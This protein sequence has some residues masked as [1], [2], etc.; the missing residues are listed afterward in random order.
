MSKLGK[1]GIKWSF[2][3]LIKFEKDKLVHSVVFPNFKE[4]KKKRE[5]TKNQMQWAEFLYF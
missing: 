2:L 5:R 1:E 3:S 4:R